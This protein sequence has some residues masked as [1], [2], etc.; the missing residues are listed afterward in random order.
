MILC[1]GQTDR[2]SNF[3]STLHNTHALCFIKARNRSR[4]HNGPTNAL[5]SSE[6]IFPKR[7]AVDVH[8]YANDGHARRRR[9]VS[10]FKHRLFWKQVRE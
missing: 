9:E 3:L 1:K 8:D 5:V 2:N 4:N 6:R 10:K 7:G